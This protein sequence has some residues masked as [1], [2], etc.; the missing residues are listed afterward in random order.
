[1]YGILS[2]SIP[3]T[4]IPVLAARKNDESIPFRLI[5]RQFVD[6]RED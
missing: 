5:S 3:K 2:G 1:M 6:L 4:C